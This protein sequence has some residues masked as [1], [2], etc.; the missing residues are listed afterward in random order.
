M[1]TFYEAAMCLCS[2]DVTVSLYSDEAACF[3]FFFFF[4]FFFFILLGQRVFIVSWRR[5]V[6][7]SHVEAVAAC[8]YILFEQRVY[9]HMKQQCVFIPMKQ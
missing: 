2:Y 4:C 5:R 6:V 8:I 3:F 1:F 9:I 7:F